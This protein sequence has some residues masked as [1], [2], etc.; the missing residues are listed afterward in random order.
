MRTI[1]AASLALF[2]GIASADDSLEK[3][4]R[5]VERNLGEALKSVGQEIKKTG[6]GGDDKKDDKKAAKSGGGAKEDRK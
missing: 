3:A 2:F 6:I 5:K 4:A 1:V